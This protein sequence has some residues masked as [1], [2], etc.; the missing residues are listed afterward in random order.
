MVGGNF[1]AGEPAALWAGPRTEGFSASKRNVSAGNARVI[2]R[3]LACGT[4]GFRTMSERYCYAPTQSQAV[5]S[6]NDDRVPGWG[7][8]LRPFLRRG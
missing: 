8:L 6:P 3:Q 5:Y 7:R 4:T 1:Q 2:L